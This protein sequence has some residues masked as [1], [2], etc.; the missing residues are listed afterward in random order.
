VLLVEARA[1]IDLGH[2]KLVFVREED[3]LYSL[4]V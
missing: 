3:T 4:A 2:S 1:E